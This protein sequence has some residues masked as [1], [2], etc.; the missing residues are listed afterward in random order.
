MGPVGHHLADAR[1]LL[2]EPGGPD[3]RPHMQHMYHFESDHAMKTKEPKPTSI[4]T[5]RKGAKLRRGRLYLRLF[6]GRSDPAVTPDGWGFDGP[7]FGPLTTVSQTY[8]SLIRLIDE[9][10]NEL[11]LMTHRDLLCWQESYFGDMT[12]FVAEAG[13]RA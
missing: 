5:V 4:P 12:V 7:I 11:S 3:A 1:R 9:H 10:D 8:F 2:I 6:H 13:Q